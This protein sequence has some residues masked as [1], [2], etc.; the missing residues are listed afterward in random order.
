MGD[1]LRHGFAALAL[2][3]MAACEAT[4]PLTSSPTPQARPPAPVAAPKPEPQPSAASTELATYY[5]RVQNDLLVQGLLRSDGGGPDTPF[6][7]RQLVEN[8]ET[9]AF[10]DEYARGQ[11]FRRSGGTAGRLKRWPGP[12]RMALS[13]GQFVSPEQQA[14]DRAAVSNYAARLRRITGHPIGM[15][16]ASPNFHVFFM[17]E[18]D[19]PQLLREVQKIVP[20]INPAALNIFADLPRSIHCLVIAFSGSDGGYDY[21]RAI[22]LIRAEHPDLMRLSCI[23]EELAQGL[24][25]ANDSPRARPSIFNDDD[26]FA[27]LTT[28]DEMLLKILYDPRLSPGMTLDEARPVVEAEANRLLGGES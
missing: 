2:L 27:L 1:R 24:G 7:A 3:A 19:R 14:K 4:A 6:S 23:H 20:N 11:G 15:S 16:E 21:A 17:G 12:V 18:D 26:E 5:R 22:A 25:L 10:Y 9:I 13:F 28:H 8:F